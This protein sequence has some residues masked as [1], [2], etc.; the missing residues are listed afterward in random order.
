MRPGQAGPNIICMFA[1]GQTL[2][3]I[4]KW[5]NTA[6]HAV[7]NAPFL[8]LPFGANL[9]ISMCIWLILPLLLH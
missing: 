7:D 3:F 4:A 8:K 6:T 9:G 2:G 5:G 1:R